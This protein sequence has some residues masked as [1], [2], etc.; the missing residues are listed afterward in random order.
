MKAASRNGTPEPGRQP[1]DRASA[2]CSPSLPRHSA[3]L[4]GRCR[5][6]GAQPD[7]A[8]TRRRLRRRG[9][10]ALLCG[11][12]HGLGQTCQNTTTVTAAA[13]P[14]RRLR[15]PPG[16]SYGAGVSAGVRQVS[17]TARHTFLCIFC[18]CATC[19]HVVLCIFCVCAA[20]LHLVP[21]IFCVSVMRQVHLDTAHIQPVTCKIH[22]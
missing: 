14:L 11:R 9:Q 21:C 5:V 8:S 17:D 2:R 18:V 19:L 3:Q 16:G 7:P 20:C 13:A 1:R 4:S 15:S 6:L 10:S 12:V 22:H